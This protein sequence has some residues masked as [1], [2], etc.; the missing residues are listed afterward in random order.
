[1]D[2]PISSNIFLQSLYFLALGN[3][4]NV[5]LTGPYPQSTSHTATS[6]SVPGLDVIA[7]IP[8]GAL[9]HFRLANAA[10]IT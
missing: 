7:I 5:F 3:L 2:L 8:W 4:A 9:F 10:D 6:F 1:M